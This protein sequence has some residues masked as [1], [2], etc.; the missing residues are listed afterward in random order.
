MIH[1]PLEI[2]QALTDAEAQQQKALAM[3]R[4]FMLGSAEVDK[5]KEY[6]ITKDFSALTP[7]VSEIPSENNGNTDSDTK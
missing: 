2:K 6:S 4:G 5:A 3:L 1:L 7:Q